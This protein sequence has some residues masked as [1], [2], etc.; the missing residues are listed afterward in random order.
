M[1]GQERRCR[2]L[3]EGDDTTVAWLSPTC[4][5]AYHSGTR[6]DEGLC[7]AARTGAGE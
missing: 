3:S 4:T 2:W 5:T 7:D 1:D 6:A